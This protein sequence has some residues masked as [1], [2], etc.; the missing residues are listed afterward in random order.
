VIVLKEQR[1]SGGTLYIAASGKPYPVS[2]V[3]PNGGGAGAVNFD[4]WDKPV[5]I[6]VPKGVG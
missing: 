4:Q 3:S 2:I 1:A 5:P 6:S